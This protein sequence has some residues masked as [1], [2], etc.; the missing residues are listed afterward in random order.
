MDLTFNEL[1]NFSTFC[2]QNMDKELPVSVTYKLFNLAKEVSEKLIFFDEENK[3]ILEK[4]CI[5]EDGKI[6]IKRG[7]EE[8]YTKRCEELAA[9]RTDI[10]SDLLTMEDIKYFG[11]ISLSDFLRLQNFIKD[12]KN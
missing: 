12:F 2:K 7:Q 3:K 5:V 9:L 8:A 1:I 11:D 4:N 10:K 6:I